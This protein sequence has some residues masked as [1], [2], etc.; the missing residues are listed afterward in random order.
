MINAPTG[1]SQNVTGR[2][3][4]MVVS[5]PIP[6]STPMAVPITQPKKHRPIFCQVRATPKPITML[7]RMS[8]MSECR[9]P[10]RNLNSQS[11]DEDGDIGDDQDQAEQ[12]QWNCANLCLGKARQH[13]ADREGE[14]EPE[15][16]QEERKG[17]ARQGHEDERPPLPA[18]H[19]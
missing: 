7:E 10:K 6:G 5:G 14:D 11:H 9:R 2:I 12:Q 1:E 15:W 3:M 18:L 19:A 8:G 16:M 4:A 17:E 13:D